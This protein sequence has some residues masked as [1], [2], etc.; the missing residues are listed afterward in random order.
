[1]CSS[2]RDTIRPEAHSPRICSGILRALTEETQ[3]FSEEKRSDAQIQKAVKELFLGLAPEKTDE[4]KRLWD[5]YQLQFCLFTDDQGVLLEG[6]LTDTCISTTVRC[7]SSGSAPLLP[8][9]PTAVRSRSLVM[10]SSA[11]LT[12]YGSFLP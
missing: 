4:L 6:G 7:E 10:K 3:L 1:M 2:Q 5:D 9:R 8:G 12:A 11:A